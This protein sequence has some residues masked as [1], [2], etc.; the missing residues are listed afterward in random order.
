MSCVLIQVPKKIC[1]EDLYVHEQGF[2]GIENV[3]SRE[4]A[5]REEDMVIYFENF[6]HRK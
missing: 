2:S 4:I 6:M 5:D 1:Y 3:K